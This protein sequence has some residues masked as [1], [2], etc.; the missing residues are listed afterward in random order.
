MHD[1]TTHRIAAEHR[2]L[3]NL[4]EAIDDALGAERTDY[5]ALRT[6][7]GAL[8]RDYIDVHH[9]RDAL[10]VD[11]LLATSGAARELLATFMNDHG[12]RFLDALDRF[13]RLLDALLVDQL[14][15]RGDLAECGRSATAQLRAQI[16]AEESA[17]LPWA[18][19]S[20]HEA[21]WRAIDAEADRLPSRCADAEACA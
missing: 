15:D 20:L 9:P 17:T 19:K 4:A 8:R 7:V 18:R 3:L 2:C 13:E 5:A 16:A 1:H 6:L 14:V 10:L 12:L 11:R 21:D